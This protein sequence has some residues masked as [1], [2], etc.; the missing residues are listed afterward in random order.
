M[1]IKHYRKTSTKRYFINSDNDIGFGS[2]QLICVQ[3]INKE[4][5]NKKIHYNKFLVISLFFNDCDNVF[6]QRDIINCNKLIECKY[7]CYYLLKEIIRYINIYLNDRKTIASNRFKRIAIEIED[8]LLSIS[9]NPKR[10]L[11]DPKTLIRFRNPT[12][13]VQLCFHTK[14]ELWCIIFMF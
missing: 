14:K 2:I 13:P 5:V 4:L 10:W 6:R 11:Y 12:E 8:T 7:N 9:I 1:V 3:K